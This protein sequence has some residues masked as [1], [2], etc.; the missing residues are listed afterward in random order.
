MLKRLS[1][2]VLVLAGLILVLLYWLGTGSLGEYWGAGEPHGTPLDASLVSSRAEGQRS[3]AG[4]IGV[5]RPKQILFGDLHVHSTF[6]LDAFMM[7]LPTGGG[8][9]AHPVADAC[10]FARYCSALDFWSINDHA[11]SLTREIWEDTI[12]AIRQCND[13]AS[14][15]QNPDVSAFLG[16]EWTQ[17]GTNPDNHYGHKNVILR[18]LAEDEV[19]TRPIAARPPAD[20]FDRQAGNLQPGRL[21]MGIAALARPTQD[22]WDLIR[23]FDR[24]LGVPDCPDGVPV[25][26]LPEDCRES[27]LD[28]AGLFSKLDDWGVDSMVIPHGTTWGYYTPQG[29]AWDKQLEPGQHDPAR[30]GL[31]EIYSGHGNSEEYRDWREVESAADG[32][33]S[34][35]SPRDDF[36]PSCWRAGEIIA[37]RCKAAG[38]SDSECEERAAQARQNYVDADVRGHLTVPGVN[39]EEWLDSGQ[40]RDCFQPSF[41]Y[42][43]KSSVQYIMA[44]RSFEGDDEPRRFD[45]G[46][47]A[48]SDN[49]TSRPGTGYKEYGR[50][51]NT[52]ARLTQAGSKVLGDMIPVYRGEA[53]PRSIPFDPKKGGA[54]FTLLESERASSFFLTGG[55]IAVHSDGRSRDAVWNAMQRKE[56]Y[57]TSGPRILLW[58][59]LLN[60]GG[61]KG[62]SVPMGG[63]V[64]L[65]AAPIFQVRAV[66]SFEQKPGCSGGSVNALGPEDLQRLC[67]GEC[68]NPSDQRRL[69]TRIEVV[70]IRPQATPGE[71]VRP[72]I[73]DPWR[74][75][76]CEADPAGCAVTFTDPDFAGSGR[77]ALY[78]VRAI[79]APIPVVNAGLLRCEQD[80][81]GR[82][83]SVDP[84]TGDEP[85][86]DDCLAE[87]EQRA[88][89]SPIF[90]GWRAAQGVVE[91]GT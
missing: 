8:E 67:R 84:C 36:L 20:A 85:A 89:S 76:D 81:A 60:P 50:V 4:E 22:T 55:L 64:D 69:I 51:Y 44:L 9:G 65:A 91:D 47:M 7:A 15:P 88:W 57:G 77:D 75:F 3:A 90:V 41:N 37:A 17:M 39:V 56:V 23:Y 32:S 59:D 10:D 45:F 87:D 28:P 21:V 42:R 73:E 14:D 31:I 48:S 70:R 1:I 13:V 6:S 86:S 53:E 43:P 52:E 27:T 29:S 25:R 71:E 66:G 79:E 80:E 2:V 54:F 19:P 30:Q 40:C 72:L 61:S 82:C 74:V 68:Y 35:P 11:V 34:C 24:M 26:A 16:W 78:Y 63:E 83:L 33:R 58:F 46:F 5:S 18:G 12:D 62:R 38:E 49:H